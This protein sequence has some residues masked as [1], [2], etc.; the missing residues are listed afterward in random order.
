MSQWTEQAI[1]L[2]KAIILQFHHRLVEESDGDEH[3]IIN[4]KTVIHGMISTASDPLS[5]RQVQQTLHD[6]ARNLYVQFCFHR[7]QTNDQ[8]A[9]EDALET[10]DFLYEHEG[11]PQ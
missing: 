4:L 5:R 11:W 6:Y 3:Y 10:F 9:L 2:G 7:D 8:S 1:I